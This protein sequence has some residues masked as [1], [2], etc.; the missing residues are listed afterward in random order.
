MASLWRTQM[1]IRLALVLFTMNILVSCSGSPSSILDG[2]TCDAPCWRGIVVGET[3][4]D[5]ALQILTVI[6]EVEKETLE[7]WSSN[8]IFWRYQGVREYASS[9]GFRDNKVSSLSIVYD[10]N[11]IYLKKFIEKFDEPTLVYVTSTDGVYPIML[12]VEFIY[13]EKGICLFHQ[14]PLL[15]FQR[16]RKYAISEKTKIS[17][18]DFVDPSIP[19]GQ[20]EEGCLRGLDEDTYNQYVREWTGYGKYEVFVPWHTR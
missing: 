20:L 15:S 9:M 11:T 19:N 7:S 1:K 10:Q 13:L 3:T 6:P 5:E 12:T 2:K 17:R 18:L 16:P 4:R 14:P 8:Y